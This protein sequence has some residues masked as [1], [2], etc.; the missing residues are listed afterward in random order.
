MKNVEI[1]LTEEALSDIVYVALG[2]LSESGQEMRG[3][4]VDGIF[5]FRLQ[6]FFCNILIKQ[7]YI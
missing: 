3:K 5:R 1:I 6:L 7:F 2:G 4:R